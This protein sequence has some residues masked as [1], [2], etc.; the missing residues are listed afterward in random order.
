VHSLLIEAGIDA[1]MTRA[2][3]INVGLRERALVAKNNKA[4]VFVSFHFNGFD[5]K[6]QGTECWV[7]INA[8]ASS[9]ALAKSVLSGVQ[10]ATGY[11]DRGVKRESFAVLSP[12]HHDAE[13]AACLIEISF[14]D[15]AS[16]EARLRTEKY[17]HQ[18]AKSALEGI[19]R[20]LRDSDRL[21]DSHALA[22]LASH[23]AA[24]PQDGFSAVQD[25]THSA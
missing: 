12:A 17:L 20:F 21:D 23:E 19:L 22:R 13:T 5:G 8:S 15:V 16:D 18:L 2:D 14:L 24:L 25:S 1:L 6:T 10:G 3:D 7:H 9:E 4:D 11:R